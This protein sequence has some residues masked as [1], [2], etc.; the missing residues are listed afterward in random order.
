VLN[1][2][3]PRAPTLVG[4]KDLEY[5][6]PFKVSG[7]YGYV[8]AGSFLQILDLSNPSQPVE[9]GRISLPGVGG[10]G[11]IDVVGNRAFVTPNTDIWTGWLT[12]IDV[13]NATAPVELG[14]LYLL[15]SPGPPQVVGDFA[16]LRLG[17]SWG[18]DRLVVL[19]VRDPSQMVEV[20][21]Y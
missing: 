10:G 7:S 12:V 13:A 14:S 1:V 15:D 2:S 11:G 6:G 20:G 17:D 8:A 19:N 5:T 16:Y 3:N 9:A 4:V 21:R 18:G